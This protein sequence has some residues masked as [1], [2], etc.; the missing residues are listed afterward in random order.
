MAAQDSCRQ[1]ALTPSLYALHR[2][3]MKLQPFAHPSYTTTTTT[4]WL[5][6][7]CVQAWCT[8]P[9]GA[10]APSCGCTGQLQAS[11]GPTAWPVGASPAGSG[12]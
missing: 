7:C 10:Q 1:P 11:S 3:E 8:G 4:P 9:P 12:P 6:H 2:A 5:A